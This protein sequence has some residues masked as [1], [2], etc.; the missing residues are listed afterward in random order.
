M[1]TETITTDKACKL[2]YS[3][4]CERFERHQKTAARWSKNIDKDYLNNY[5]TYSLDLFQE[6]YMMKLVEQLCEAIRNAPDTKEGI[7]EAFT[8]AI[9]SLSFQLRDVS[10]LRSKS[11]NS[12]YNECTTIQYACK[13]EMVEFI[14]ALATLL[15]SDCG[16][17]AICI[18]NLNTM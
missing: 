14:K 9:A 13:V 1:I 4:I 11:S 18:F 12:V 17:D 7:G 8:R 10:N 6:K 2:V 15:N 16:E 5:P 3:K